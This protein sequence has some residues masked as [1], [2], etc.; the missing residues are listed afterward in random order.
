MVRKFDLPVIAAGGIMDGA[1]I[2]AALR[3]GA[4]AA[5]MGT[6]FVGCPESSADQGYRAALASDAALAWPNEIK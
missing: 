1:G 3:L 6:A 5:Q 2:A 4:A